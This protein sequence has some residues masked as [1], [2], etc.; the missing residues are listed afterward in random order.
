MS[1]GKSNA[2]LGVIGVLGVGGYFGYDYYQTEKA[3]KKAVE[4][5]AHALEVRNQRANDPSY[6]P[7]GEDP[8]VDRRAVAG[9]M[10]DLVGLTPDQAREVL[11][12]ANFKLDNFKTLEDSECQYKDEKDMKPLGHICS[13]EPQAGAKTMAK[14]RI[15]VV[16]EEDTYEEGGLGSPSAWK[17]MPKLDGLSPGA[18]KD[19]LRAKGFAEDEFRFERE[20]GCGTPGL[21]CSTSPEGDN[22]KIRGRQ[23]TVTIGD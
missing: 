19:L 12:K 3:K 13:Q 20:Q 9:E 2:L 11:T 21:V 4:D 10:P 17:R 16:I 1:S 5:N 15:E 8:F 23:G 14:A 6:R 18:A 7:S 22:R